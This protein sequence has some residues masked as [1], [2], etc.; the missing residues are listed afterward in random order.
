MKNHTKIFAACLILSSIII[1]PVQATNCPKSVTRKGNFFFSGEYPGW[2]SYD[3][4][5]NNININIAMTQFG[6]IIYSLETKRL[7]CVYITNNPQQPWFALISQ[8]L[9]G[10]IIPDIHI[11]NKQQQSVW[12]YN[13]KHK[14]L[15]CTTAYSPKGRSCHYTIEDVID[16]K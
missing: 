1:S 7:A 5:S 4:I 2:Q 12:Q 9:S 15:T 8:P 10:L 6:G 11:I 13:T 3:Q 14:D 16:I